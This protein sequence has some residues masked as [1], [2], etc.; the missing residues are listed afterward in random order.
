MARS[1]DVVV[2][3]AGPGGYVCAIR[4][5]QAGL[6]TLVIEREF[7]GGVCLNVG[8][9]PSKAL[10][11]ASKVYR[12]AL[13]GAAIGIVAKD[14]TVDMA[15]MQAWKTGVTTKLSQGIGGL[16]KGN[17]VEHVI[18]TGK[19]AGPGK[20]EITL[21]DGSVEVVET[22]SVVLATGSRPIQIPGFPFDNLQI[23]DS[24]GALA[25]SEIPGALAV[26]GG[27]VIGM[28]M[29][30]VYARLGSK[31]TVIEALDRILPTFDPD[32]ARPVT[33][34]QAKLGVKHLVATKAL[35]QELTA[36]GKIA[37]DLE[38]TDKKGTTQSRLEVDKV[39]VS[40]GRRPSSHG[41]GLET[42]GITPDARGFVPVDRQMKTSAPGVYAIGDL[43]PGP[44]LAHKASKEGE[45]AAEVIAG[46]A[47][48][49]D[50]VCIPSV[51]YTDPEIATVGPML[52]ELEAQGRKI[53]VG[54]F[55]FAALGRA[56][57]SNATDGFARVVADA[58]DGT[59]LAVHIVG[60][61]ASEL[62]A[63]S[64]LALEMSATAEDLA[65]TIH[66]HPTMAEALA[67]AAHIV[68]GHPLHAMP[69]P[70]R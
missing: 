39:L 63:Q 22:K 18:G 41:I 36:D 53:K 45:I 69:T 25:L 50:S 10:I 26:I 66:A 17:K 48:A 1:V 9:I 65:L 35:R 38:T 7:L 4:L 68:T 30:D 23:L 59:I 54:K 56:I 58:D 15:A 70:A 47:A 19:L 14:L 44:M 5:G 24:T 52:F 55:Q 37:I 31:V 28:E 11:H 43:V 46:H 6:K 60:A 61:E 13:D 34:K 33:M 20:V 3:G 51:V 42:V 67:E 32:L 64:G 57:S 8:C 40:V 29:A 21:A 62:I 12:K 2:L 49:F 16:F 27:G